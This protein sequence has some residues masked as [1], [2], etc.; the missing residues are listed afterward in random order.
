MI[1][2]GEER[3]TEEE[4]SIREG[5]VDPGDCLVSGDDDAYIHQINQINQIQQII[6]YARYLLNSEISSEISPSIHSCPVMLSPPRH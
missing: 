5:W 2:Q 4:Q 1:A 6:D 3:A